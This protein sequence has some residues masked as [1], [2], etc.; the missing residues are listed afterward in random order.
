MLKYCFFSPIASPHQVRFCD[1][2]RKYFDAEFYFY[3][4]IGARQ[5]FWAVP[6][7]EHCHILPTRFKWRSRYF[8]LSVIRVLEAQRPDIIMIGG[9][10][11]IPANYL[12]YRWGKKHGVKVVVQ[13][14]RSRVM[15][16]GKLRGYTLTWRLLHWLYRD[17]D[18]VMVTA[19][20]AV[21]QFRDT[22]RFGDKVVVGRYPCDL[23]RYYLHPVRTKKDA[24]TLIYPN[25]MTEI[26]NPLGAVEIFAEVLKRYPRTVLKM[27]AAG[28]LRQQVEARIGELGIRSSVQFLD[29]IANWDDL[30]EIYRNCDIM[31]FPAKF[32]NGN[33]TLRE[34]MAS[35]MVCITS[36]KVM[37]IPP[38]YIEPRGA[39]CVLPPETTAF[40][41]RICWTIEHPDTFARNAEVN[42]AAIRHTTLAGTAELYYE[43]LGS[44]CGEG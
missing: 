40:A 1:Y 28:E 18:R 44:I 20:D 3:D 15:S 11:S 41:D 30:G 8:T 42:R 13:T 21:E 5:S 24:Y 19:V 14:E 31:F 2:L 22:F 16:T 37:G 9:G 29:N 33:Y 36:T 35:G 23:D 12:A 43:L 25:R 27:N 4:R 26:Y 34:C 32:S 6:L 7:G 38:E 10:L 17:I 39:V